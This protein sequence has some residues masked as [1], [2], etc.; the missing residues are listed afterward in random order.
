MAWFTRGDLY[1]T[2]TK[3]R[4]LAGME[5]YL[6]LAQHDLQASLKM[7]AKPY[8]SALYLLNVAILDGTPESRRHWLELGDAIDP[9]NSLVRLRYMFS[10]RPRWGGSYGE[11]EAF[12]QQSASKHVDQTLLAHM[13][14]LIHSDLADD[15]M[16]ARDSKQVF[17]QEAEVIS[18][19]K[20]AHEDP[21]TETLVGYT[22]SA[23][24][25]HRSAELQWGLRQLSTRHLENAWSLSQIGWIYAE[26]HR[27]QQA[28]PLLRQAAA[29]NDPWS[30]FVVGKTIYQGCPDLRLQPDRSLGLA[31]IQ[32]AANQCFPDATRFLASLGHAAAPE[33]AGR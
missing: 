6:V 21:S 4:Q 5:R 15:A 8:L 22:R 2:E 27:N 12:L 3:Q 14:V 7:T 32:R 11:M 16:T 24:D 13:A 17:D 10:L 29:L 9:R 1:L 18:L 28:W 23:W 25:L 33:C 31:W 20:R 30:Q 19:S 26:E